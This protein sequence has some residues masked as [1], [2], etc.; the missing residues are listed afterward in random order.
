MST[1]QAELRSDKQGPEQSEPLRA[2]EDS[3]AISLLRA[4]E[5]IMGCFRPLL[6]QHDMTEQQ[7]R[8]IRVLAEGK[9]MEIT[10]LAWQC[11]ILLPSMS[12]ILKRLECRGLIQRTPD[13]ADQRRVLMSLTEDGFLLVRR[14]DPKID[15]R[16]HRIE[17]AFGVD[18][19]QQ[20]HA[21]LAE[22]ESAVLPL[23][24]QDEQI[25][26]ARRRQV[27]QVRKRLAN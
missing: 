21:L 2:F 1:K 15:A 11:C 26:A 7:W 3:V 23:L 16:Q 13:E 22:L 5:T 8:I 19:T 18:K 10:E 6:A 17:Q 9:R 20:L 27:E 12:G 24:E 14:V 4:R 25:P